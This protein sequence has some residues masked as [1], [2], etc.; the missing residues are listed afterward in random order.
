[1][2]D[3]LQAAVLLIIGLLVVGALWVR[4][5]RTARVSGT[6]DLTQESN[7]L[8]KAHGTHVTRAK[9]NALELVSPC[10]GAT[11]LEDPE[12]MKALLP[13]GSTFDV[14]VKGGFV[15]RRANLLHGG[16]RRNHVAY[17]FE[18]SYRREIESND[19]H[20]IVE[21]RSFGP[22]R[23]AKILS[24]ADDMQLD[25]GAPDQRLF[26]GIIFPESA[27]GMTAGPL[28]LVA[29]AMLRPGHDMALTCDTDLAMLE[30]DPLSGKT[31]RLT[32]VNGLGVQS[33][34]GLGWSLTGV[35]LAFLFCQNV[36]PEGVSSRH[37]ADGTI[38]AKVDA[39]RLIA[40]CDP[41]RPPCDDFSVFLESTVSSDGTVSG[42]RVLRIPDDVLYAE[43]DAIPLTSAQM[44]AAATRMGEIHYDSSGTYVA[45]ATLQWHFLDLETYC[46]RLLFELAKRDFLDYP[47][48]T[49]HYH[50]T[51]LKDG[52]A[53]TL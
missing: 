22:V 7:V 45:S 39:R 14:L 11:L 35:Q 51:R 9:F 25:L 33:V 31:V 19:G 28:A 32:Y 2:E 4:E 46:D 43:E 1:V 21:T 24:T 52:I 36:L 17:A 26:D 15:A 3:V 40:F 50:C 29:Q 34:E 48:F 44:L 41:S 5:I 49:V 53:R 6:T 20:Q 8:L 37:E 12:R 38:F 16:P 13:A 23:M 42:C 10:E 47:T 18:M 27:A 30:N